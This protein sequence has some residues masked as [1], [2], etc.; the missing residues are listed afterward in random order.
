MGTYF[1]RS[2]KFREDSEHHRRAL[3]Y[4]ASRQEETGES[5]ATIIA[6]LIEK[7]VTIP[8]ELEAMERR[9]IERIDELEEHI[10][11]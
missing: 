7:G 6:D 4:L 2:V 1:S 8:D 9:I 5:F 10:G 11:H 3:E